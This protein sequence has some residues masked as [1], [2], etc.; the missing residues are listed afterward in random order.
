MED[1]EKWT[2]AYPIEDFM[3]IPIQYKIETKT[4]SGDLNTIINSITQ[5]RPTLFLDEEAYTVC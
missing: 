1:E 2:P 3:S 5:F 4:K